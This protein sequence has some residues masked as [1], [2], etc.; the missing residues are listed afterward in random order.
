MAVC[1]NAVL[2]ATEK[3]LVALSL[4]DGTVLWKQP[5][6]AP[7]AP[8]GLAVDGS[9]RAAVTLSDGRVVCFG[10]SKWTM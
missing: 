10:P 7:P 4:A 9:G 2:L 1:Q 6:P 5:L 3:E 8:W